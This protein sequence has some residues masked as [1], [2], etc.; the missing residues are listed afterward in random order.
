MLSTIG[1][2]AGRVCYKNG[3]LCVF[4]CGIGQIPEPCGMKKETFFWGSLGYVFRFVVGVAVAVAAAVG[5][6]SFG[7]II[8]MYA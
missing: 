7:A 5:Y 3:H 1:V 2:S 6:I 4:V 8:C